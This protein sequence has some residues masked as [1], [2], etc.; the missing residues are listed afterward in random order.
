M[1]CSDP[2]IEDDRRRDAEGDHVGQ[3]IEL[4]AEPALRRCSSRAMR[5]SSRRARR[6]RTIAGDRLLPFAGDREADAGQARAERQRGDRIGHDRAQRDAA[7]RLARAA[8]PSLGDALDQL[9]DAD[10]ADDR[11]AGD[12]AL[13]EQD[14]RRGAGGQIDVDPAAEADQA[15]ALAGD[16][17]V[18]RLDPGHDPPRDQPG[19][20]GEAD[21]RAV[22]ALDQDVLAL[23]VL[24]RLVEIGVEE[25]A[26]D[27]DDLA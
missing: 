9:G 18:A 23:I 22:L 27:I 16:D 5:P 6:R 8:P 2:E 3:R 20:L 17:P 19:D 11:L 14:L 10:P 7:P 4:G 12:G 15:D 21:P 24:A 25:L 13:A 26:G 1:S